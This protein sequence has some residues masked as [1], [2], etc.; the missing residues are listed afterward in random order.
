MGE[1]SKVVVV[2]EVEVVV[3]EDSRVVVDRAVLMSVVVDVI[4][5]SNVDDV[6]W[7]TRRVVVM[8]CGRDTTLLHAEMIK[9][10]AY[11]D[12]ADG[13]ASEG[14]YRLRIAATLVVTTALAVMTT[15]FET[16]DTTDNVVLVVSVI[17]FVRVV[18]TVTTE[19]CVAVLTGT[20]YCRTS[21]Q[22]C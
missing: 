12:S 2:V 15:R 22:K 9:P 20:G 16:V 6:V 3:V 5:V 4:D 1:G 10:V 13:V 18:K 21:E 17:V 8:A 11:P 7:M 19:V 14:W